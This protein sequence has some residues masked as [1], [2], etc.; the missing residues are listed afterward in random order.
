MSVIIAG[1]S[2]CR[3]AGARLANT[4]AK[5]PPG[6]T[7]QTHDAFMVARSTTRIRRRSGASCRTP[8]SGP[9]DPDAEG[10]RS[11]G[12]IHDPSEVRFELR[13]VDLLAKA[14][15]E[16]RAVRSPS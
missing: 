5:N 15:R 14:L 8:V 9:A 6:P 3:S 7:A 10:R 13:E 11:E 2:N 16:R 4:Y 1:V 12:A